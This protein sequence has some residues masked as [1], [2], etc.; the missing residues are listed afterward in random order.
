MAMKKIRWLLALAAL[1]A[2]AA[3]AQGVRLT[4]IDLDS[5]DLA[6]GLRYPAIQQTVRQSM[7]V[8]KATE[9]ADSEYELLVAIAT[10][11]R[12]ADCASDVIVTVR[13]G[14][15]LAGN[16]KF[17]TRDN[18]AFLEL[19]RHG[20]IVVSPTKDHERDFLRQVERSVQ[21]CFGQLAF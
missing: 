18:K 15:T 19:C 1:L 12:P 14:I 11:R 3:Q 10:V 2:G 17:R 9:F 6:C 20:G 16:E 8:M 21:V 7:A 13:K 5:D 4:I